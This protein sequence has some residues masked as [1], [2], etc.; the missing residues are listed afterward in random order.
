V[1][2]TV[3]VVRK[4]VRDE[5][6]RDDIPDPADQYWA[7]FDDRAAAEAHARAL[8]RAA[9]LVG[10]ATP[11]NPFARGLEAATSL[12]EPVFRDWLL[13]GGIDPP[14]P[15]PPPA[16]PPAGR[17]LSQPE[18]RRAEQSAR[19]RAA[20][21]WRD[22]WDRDLDGGRLLTRDQLGRVLDALDRLPPW[23]YEVVAVAA[24]GPRRAGPVFAVVHAHWY[25]DDSHFCGA[26]DAVTV[27][28]TRA[29][30]E[31]AR[32]RRMKRPEPTFYWDG[33]RDEYV[34]VEL[35]PDPGEG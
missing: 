18:R 30:A 24:A 35:Q 7:A 15:V 21:A 5:V 26:N 19:D 13:D 9:V 22:W 31:A 1:A 6:S 17:G 23:V 16:P 10:G 14:P 25:Y 29:E 12:P 8:G 32:D 11:E 27:Y 34:V 28:R 33:D 4:R 2:G 3:F 20:G